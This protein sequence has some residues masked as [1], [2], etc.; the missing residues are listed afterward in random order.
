MKT[1]HV[2]NIRKNIKSFDLAK[3]WTDAPISMMQA[4]GIRRNINNINSRGKLYNLGTK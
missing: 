4:G 2:Q 1:D 3:Y